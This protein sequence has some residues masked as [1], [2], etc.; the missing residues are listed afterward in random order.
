MSPAATVAQAI[1]ER[2]RFF[3]R[4]YAAAD[5][6]SLVDGYFATDDHGPMALP[7]G[8]T[9]PVRGRKALKQMFAG[10][11][12]EMPVIRLETVELVASDAVASETGRAFLTGKD[13]SQNIGRFVVCWI[14]TSEGWRAKTDFFA[15]D[16]W[17]D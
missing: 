5:A 6:A 8:A 10:M 17:P 3:E 9:P 11:I 16:G 13:G 4:A 14:M 2:A 15:E 12:P 7:P 1:A